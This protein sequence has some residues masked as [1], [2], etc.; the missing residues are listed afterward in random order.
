MS[1]VDRFQLHAVVVDHTV[2]GDDSSTAVNQLEMMAVRQLAENLDLFDFVPGLQ[3]PEEYGRHMIRESGHFD[4]DENLEG[5]YDY[6]RYGEQQLR[7][8]R[9]L[10]SCSVVTPTRSSVRSIWCSEAGR[11]RYSGLLPST[12]PRF[13]VISNT[14]RL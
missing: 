4:Y 8:M 11:Y 7:Q 13:G 2:R 1:V 9:I 5:F 10:A 6:R 14:S 12:R 3:T